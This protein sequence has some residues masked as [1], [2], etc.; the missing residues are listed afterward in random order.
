[1][2][3]DAEETSWSDV[4]VERA[5]RPAG[6]RAVALFLPLVNLAGRR[7]RGGGEPYC[8]PQALWHE[9]SPAR[10]QKVCF[11]LSLALT[12]VAPGW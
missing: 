1:M 7:Q 5:R 10:L 12:K 3:G 2:K 4:S 9:H 11:P 8:R 6:L